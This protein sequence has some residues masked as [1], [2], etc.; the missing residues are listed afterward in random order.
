MYVEVLRYIVT[1]RELLRKPV[2][3]AGEIVR[4]SG[5]PGRVVDE[6]GM[7]QQLDSVRR[8]QELLRADKPMQSVIAELQASFGVDSTDAIAAIVVGRSLNRAAEEELTR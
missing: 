2:E 3:K 8:A 6:S 5:E 1:D 7:G 4:I